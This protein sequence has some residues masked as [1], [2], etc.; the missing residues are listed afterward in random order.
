MTFTFLPSSMF[1]VSILT[2]ESLSGRDCSWNKPRACPTKK[3]N[4]GHSYSSHG[5]DQ[6]QRA[7]QISSGWI[8]VPWDRFNSHSERTR[9]PQFLKHNLNPIFEQ[10]L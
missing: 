9:A 10:I 7:Y 2:K 3:N 8:G 1:C 6:Y 5:T 4:K